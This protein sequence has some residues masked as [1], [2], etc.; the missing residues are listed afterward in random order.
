MCSAAS[1]VTAST[2]GPGPARPDKDPSVARKRLRFTMV[3][4]VRSL[5][6]TARLQTRRPPPASWRHGMTDVRTRL[7]VMMFLQYFI[8]GAWFVTMGTYLGQTLRFDATQIGL[9]Y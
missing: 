2:E 6:M 5:R 7:S 9:A 8:W 4:G 3:T 1:D